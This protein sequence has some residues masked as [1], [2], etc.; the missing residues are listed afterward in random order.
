MFFVSFYLVRYRRKLVF[1]NLAASFPEKSHDE[2]KRIEKLFYRNLAEYGV[3]TLKLLTISEEELRK[4]MVFKDFSFIT[5]HA[6]NNQSVVIYASHTFNWEWL[7]A[8]GSVHLPVQVDFVYQKVNNEFFNKLSLQS[9]TRF[10][11]FP[12][13]R[14]A[15]ARESVKRK[16]IL[17]AIAIVADQY[18]GLGRDKKFLANFLHRETAFFAGVNQLPMLLNYPVCY[19]EIKKVKRGY[20]E[21]VL[22]PVSEPPYEKTYEGPI[23][24]YIQ[25]VERSIRE[26]PDSWL[27]S[28][29]RWKTR[30]LKK[31]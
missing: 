17:R 21:T 24:D 11:G 6:A 29:N 13:E 28:H 14:F 4:R 16:N 7:L 3:E 31:S 30:H 22:L 10:G 18:P 19:A 15:V 12:I 2:L 23:V 27:W 9:R 5:R 26:R 8:A 25:L 1:K 20:Y